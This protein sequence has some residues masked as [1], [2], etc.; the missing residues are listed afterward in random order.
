ML[1][2]LGLCRG[3][4]THGKGTEDVGGSYFRMEEGEP[5]CGW[6]G[7]EQEAGQ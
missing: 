7:G 2:K 5:D 3:L 1:V 6:A 4:R